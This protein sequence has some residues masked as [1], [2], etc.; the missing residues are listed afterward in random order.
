MSLPELKRTNIKNQF[1]LHD[2]VK[3]HDCDSGIL[4]VST[5][6]PSREGMLLQF[7]YM[8]PVHYLWNIM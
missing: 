5:W 2:S 4:V 8:F 1:N 3:L 7:L 6:S